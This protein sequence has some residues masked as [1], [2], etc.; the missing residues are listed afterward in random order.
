MAGR[1]SSE[2]SLVEHPAI[3]LFGELGWETGNCFYESFGDS[4]SPVSSLLS[5][6]FVWTI[7]RGSVRNEKVLRAHRERLRR[8]C[9]T[10][11]DC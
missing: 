11:G 4:P 2:D 6:K 7:T 9:N 8:Y 5:R 3:A 10:K 1:Y